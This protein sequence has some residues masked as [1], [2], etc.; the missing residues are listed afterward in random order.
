[1]EEKDNNNLKSKVLSAIQEDG[2][3]SFDKL[4]KD[5]ELNFADLSFGMGLLAKENKILV[6]VNH[7]MTKE[8]TYKSNSEALYCRFMD[9]LFIYHLKERN[10]SFYASKL[11]VSSKYL[12]A[13][14]KEVS[15]KSPSTWI[16]EETVRDIEQL[17]CHTQTSIK[18]IA[19]QL[20][21]PNVS[22]FGKYF[23]SLKGISPK[24]YREKYIQ[25]NQF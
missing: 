2:S 10:V 25:V 23:K 21:F 4:A 3:I 15:G 8:Y 24:Q 12:T 7:F 17:L 22:F 1:M 11:C 20:N 9:L 19:Y 5:Y 13:I 14:V 16:R 18:E 6:R